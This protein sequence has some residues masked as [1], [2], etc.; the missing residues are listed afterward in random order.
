M[1]IRSLGIDNGSTFED[2]D[3]KTKVENHH[4]RG[5]ISSKCQSIAV[6]RARYKSKTV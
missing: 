3:A 5:S 2:R 6:V 1:T 4:H